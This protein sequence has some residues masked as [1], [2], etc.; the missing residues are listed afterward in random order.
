MR[1]EP[2]LPQKSAAG[3]LRTISLATWFLLL[4]VISASATETR[5]KEQE[6]KGHW[7][8]V[9][10]KAYADDLG[11]FRTILRFD[12]GRP[13]RTSSDWVKR[14]GELLA[15]WHRVMGPWPSVI[16]SPKIEVVGTQL[17]EN[18]VQRR[19][20]VEIA[21]GRLT[22]GWLLIPEGKGPFPAV[23]VPYYESD[24]SV[25]LGTPLRDFAYQLARRG[26]VTLAIGSPGGD[27]RKTD[28]HGATCQPLSY[29]A[30]VAAN[31]ANALAHLPEVD[32]NRIGIVGH[33]YGGKWALF[34]GALCDRFSAIV[35]S[36]PGIVWDETRP[37]VNY[38]E[39]WYLGYDHKAPRH[40][41]IIP[42]T[43][44]YRQLVED[45][46]DLHELLALM[47]P[48]ALLVSGGAEDPPERWRALNHVIE[49]NRLLG[50]PGRVGMSNRPTHAPTPESNEIIY[51]FLER[52][53][54]R[55]TGLKEERGALRNDLGAAH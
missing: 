20:R 2:F 3:L 16:S 35:V 10:P 9:P 41:G 32:P 51:R 38:W 30:Y 29:L 42:R 8:D 48:R 15:Y 54:G 52:F 18:F 49:V 46:R 47:A 28:L 1:V 24:T 25:G 13:V 21:S 23:F 19:V 31:C 34:A 6:G 37:N 53:L 12:D 45:K 27:A 26:F 50:Q 17:R 43:G 14:R 40:A 5:D 39:P 4:G 36:D 7:L 11:G 33:S 22:D 44:A 55:P